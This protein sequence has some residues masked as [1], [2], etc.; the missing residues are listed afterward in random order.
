[1]IPGYRDSERIVGRVVK[2]AVSDTQVRLCSACFTDFAIP[3]GASTSDIVGSH[4]L[5]VEPCDECGCVIGEEPKDE[6]QRWDETLDAIV[7]DDFAWPER[8]HDTALVGS[9]R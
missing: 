7:R 9:K 3:V 5:A 4:P 1:M 8:P 6:F 2:V